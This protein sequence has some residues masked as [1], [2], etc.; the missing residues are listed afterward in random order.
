M[1]RFGP[2]RVVCRHYNTHSATALFDL[3]AIQ[4][5]EK[6]INSICV[7]NGISLFYF[8]FAIF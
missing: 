3:H 5:P 1:L 6:V 4:L 2:E 7:F 8:G